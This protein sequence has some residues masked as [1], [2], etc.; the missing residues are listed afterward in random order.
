M[1]RYYITFVLLLIA[2][3]AI[4]FL[5][6]FVAGFS[7]H[8]PMLVFALGVILVVIEIF[9]FPGVAVLA[10]SGIVLM[11]GSLLWAMA[12]IWPNEPIHYTG[13]VFVQPLVNLA[14]GLGI[15][16]ALIVVLAR[17]LPKG[18][19]WDRLVVGA[20]VGGSAQA[21]GK[22]PGAAPQ[23]DALIGRR[24]VAATALHPGG[25]VEVD[26]LRYEAKIEIGAV[27]AGATIVVRG[28]TDF[29][30]IVEKIET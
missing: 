4:V 30:L 27:D 10:L 7:G 14:I 8:E 11:L 1:K 29:G 6:H 26:G 25:Q 19:V 21:A 5:G 22:E 23:L 12:D 9:F 17:Y 24:G 13:D 20:T 3:L 16:V 28:R 18:W 15:A 2:L